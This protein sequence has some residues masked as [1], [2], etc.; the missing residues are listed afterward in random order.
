[1][2]AVMPRP[3][4]AAAAAISLASNCTGCLQPRPFVAAE[5][6]FLSSWF[7]AAVQEE[8]VQREREW[9]AQ[10]AAKQR[11][12]GWGAPCSTGWLCVEMGAKRRGLDNACI[13]AG[14]LGRGLDPRGP[15]SLSEEG[16]LLPPTLCV[17]REKRRQEL[18][19]HEAAVTARAE[20]LEWEEQV[21]NGGGRPANRQR[22]GCRAQLREAGSGAGAT[23]PALRIQASRG[24]FSAAVHHPRA[25]SCALSLQSQASEEQIFSCC[26][27][28]ARNCLCIGISGGAGGSK[29]A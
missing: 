17:R 8:L 1:M 9:A 19:R 18:A 10:Q 7:N 20:Q 27:P 2:T 28:P 5:S 14:Q 3:G 23:A 16:R 6:F 4:C 15:S 11:L 29:G 26:A 12:V 21:R 13:K 25:S 22:T 24:I